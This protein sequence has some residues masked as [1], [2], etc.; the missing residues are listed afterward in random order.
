VKLFNGIDEE[1]F[2]M[3]FKEKLFLYFKFFI[4]KSLLLDD[5]QL[6]KITTLNDSMS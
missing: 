5:F 4:K 6:K 1:K 3:N 2:I